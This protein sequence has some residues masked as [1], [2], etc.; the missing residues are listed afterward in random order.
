MYKPG[1]LGQ[2]FDYAEK[3]GDPGEYPYTRGVYPAM[4]RGRPWTIG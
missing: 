4:Y 3:L 2:D 1:D